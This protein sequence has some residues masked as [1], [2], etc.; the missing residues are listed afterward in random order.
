LRFVV[1]SYR[2]ALSP[3]LKTHLEPLTARGET[4][5]ETP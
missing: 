1:R 2:S 3:N 5:V 4:P